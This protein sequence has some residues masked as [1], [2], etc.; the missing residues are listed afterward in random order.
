MDDEDKKCSK[1]DKEIKEG[2]ENIKCTGLCKNLFHPKCIGFTPTTLKF[3]KECDNLI[4]V[5]EQCQNSPLYQINLTLKKMMSFMCIF[6]ERLNRQE[7]NNETIF[8]QFDI[9]NNNLE[10]I[11]NEIKTE[12]AQTTNINANSTLI[13]NTSINS[14]SFAEIT[15]KPL[16]EPTVLVKP[17][18]TQRCNDTRADLRSKGVADEFQISSVNNIPKGGLEIKC[19][20]AEQ[21]KKIHEKVSKELGDKYQIIMPQLRK[22]KVRITNMSEKLTEQEIIESIKEKNV[23]YINSEMKVICVYYMKNMDSYGTIIEVDTKTFNAMM[24]Q[25]KINIRWNVCKV[26]ECVNVLR[27]FNCCG[28]NHKS[29]MCKNKKACLRCGGEHLIKDC[30]SNQSKCINCKIAGEKLKIKLDL[31]HPVWSRSCPILQKK[32]DIQRKQT[33]YKE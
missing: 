4:Y 22:P 33:L 12:I 29:T 6:N 13:P 1:C 23:Q 9:V 25:E 30:K 16:I 17:K 27:C 3:Y 5:C 24:E 21:Q 31:N 26:A 28:Y 15:K 2:E 8:K 19:K 11:A 20:S 32:V 14:E 10:K 7:I 18:T